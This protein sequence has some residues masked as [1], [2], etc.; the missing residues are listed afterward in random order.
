MK[1]SSSILTGLLAAAVTFGCLVAFAGPPHFTQ[2]GYYYGRG[3]YD[4]HKYGCDE[5]TRTNAVKP[6]EN[7]GDEKSA[8]EDS[9]K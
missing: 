6:M 4:D 3:N 8:E 7:K 9:R 5:R 2:R 1:R